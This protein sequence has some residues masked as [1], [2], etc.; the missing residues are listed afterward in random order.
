MRPL[1]PKLSKTKQKQN[2]TKLLEG[3]IQRKLLKLKNKG[4][5]KESDY[6]QIY[7]SGCTPASSY[8]L[9]KAHK[10]NKDYPARN[11]V[12]HR[13]CPQDALSSYLIPILQPLLKKSP[14][15]CKNSSDFV[16]KIKNLRLGDDILV[17]FDAE[18]LYPSIPLSKCIKEIERRL[19]NDD[20]LAS[21]TPLLPSDIVDLINLCFSTSDFIYDGIHRTAEWL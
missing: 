20:S 4:K 15:K 21:H 18:A 3:C 6:K 17:S 11:I 14:Y 10:P 12:S 8:P 19:S 16:D 13:G 9:L 2:R 7:P 1:N 5:I